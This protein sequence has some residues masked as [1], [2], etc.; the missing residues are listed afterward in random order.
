MPFGVDIPGGGGESRRL[1][2]GQGAGSAHRVPFGVVG[3]GGG[4]SR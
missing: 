4:E 2:L 1:G 3:G